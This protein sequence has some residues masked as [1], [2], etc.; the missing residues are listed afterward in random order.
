[1]GNNEQIRGRGEI[2]DNAGPCSHP[3]VKPK[4]GYIKPKGCSKIIVE[5]DEDN[6]FIFYFNAAADATHGSKRDFD[7]S[8]VIIRVDKAGNKESREIRIA[9]V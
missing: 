6:K 3:G 8:E 9:I 1:M 2:L 7:L 5:P 4:W